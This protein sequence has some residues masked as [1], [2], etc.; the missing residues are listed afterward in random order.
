MAKRDFIICIICLCVGLLLVFRIDKDIPANQPE[1]VVTKPKETI[2]PK[3][4]RLFGMVVDDLHIVQEKIKPNEN[5]SKILSIYNVS[6]DVI[7]DLAEKSKEVFDLKRITANS[8]YTLFFSKDSVKT[9]QYFIYEPNEY[10][11]VVC[12]LNDSVNITKHSRKIDTVIHSI[13]GV[14]ENSLFESMVK[15]GADPEFVY[16]LA[17][18]FKWQIDFHKVQKGDKFKVIFEDILVENKRIGSGKIHGALFNHNGEDFYAVAFDQGNGTEYFDGEGK[19]LQKAFLKAPLKFSRISSRY[20]MKRFHPVQKRYK[21]HLGTDYAAPKGTPIQ[22]VGDGVVLEAKYN[23]GNGN[24]VKIRHDETYTTQYLHMSKIASG[25]KKGKRVRQGET[26]GYVGSTGLASGP[27]LCFRFWKNGQQVDALKVKIP[28]T[29][30]VK[31]SYKL[32]YEDVKMAM[33]AKLNA[34]EF[35]SDYYLASNK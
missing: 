4:E 26:I 3:S 19:N 16:D 5:L 20:T 34:L 2:K 24:Y 8:K 11:Y 7:Y 32:A 9:A 35:S 30:P 33:I 31:E 17:E 10:E 27:H 6:R 28:P 22:T 29:E 21:A 18:V 23:S 13:T 15:S 12:N 14:I 25:V 1:E